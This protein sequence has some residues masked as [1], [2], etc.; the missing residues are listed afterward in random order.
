MAV[1]LFGLALALRFHNLW[2]TP[3][4]ITKHELSVEFAGLALLLALAAKLGRLPSRTALRWLAVLLLLFALA[5]YMEVTAPALYGRRMNLYWDAQHLP[6]VFAML[7]EV[8][9]AW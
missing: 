5:R 9:P 2:P 4:V 1:A 7:V 6:Y 8:M 3:W